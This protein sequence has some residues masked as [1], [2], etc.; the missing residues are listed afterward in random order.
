M[1]RLGP[2]TWRVELGMH[3]NS[4]IRT[5]STYLLL[6]ESDL[7]H[8]ID[9]GWDVPG[10]WEL[11]TAGIRDLGRDLADVATITAT[12]MH[13]DHLGLAARLREASG[14]RLVLSKVEQM[15]IEDEV[16]SE[17]RP[18]EEDLDRWKV[19]GARRSELSQVP[20]SEHAVDVVADLLVDDGDYLPV[21]GRRVQVLLVPGHT[22]GSIC[23]RDEAG[24]HL[25]TGDHIL[26]D[27][28]P[29]PGLGGATQNNALNDFLESLDKVAGFTDDV[30]LP[31]HG[32]TFLDPGPRARTIAA[33]HLARTREVAE[34]MRVID[35]ASVWELARRGPWT[36][37]FDRLHDRYLLTALRQIDTHADFVR[38]G[39]ADRWL[40]A[41][42]GG[43]AG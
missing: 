37:G 13:V 9:P 8:V 17:A 5:S 7:L 30:V 26:P 42:D 38:R 36:R 1:K 18:L 34:A 11:L 25:L 27:Y 15:A 43:S 21:P 23:L 31:G 3:E 6:D 39:L 29:A 41:N 32:R 33:R 14:A 24:R 22:P 19:P 40:S 2:L 16:G 4:F 10:N 12:H 35:D 28:V 20:A